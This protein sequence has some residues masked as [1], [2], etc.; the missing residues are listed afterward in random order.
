MTELST[1]TTLMRSLDVPAL[2]RIVGAGFVVRVLLWALSS[3]SGDVRSWSRVAR[4]V[5]A[6]GVRGLYEAGPPFRQSPVSALWAGLAANLSTWLEA[7]FELV[8]KVLPLS[9]DVGLVVLILT[10]VR[11][12]GGTELDA[13]RA[14]AIQ[15]TAM[16]AIWVT[17]HHGGLDSVLIFCVVAAVFL[18]DKGDRPLLAGIALA[19]A[20]HMHVVAVVLLPALWIAQASSARGAVV[21]GL[22]LLLALS[23]LALPLSIQGPEFLVNAV[24]VGVGSNR[25]GL[26]FV[27]SEGAELAVIGSWFDVVGAVVAAWSWKLCLVASLALGLL[28]RT[29]R[30]STL[31]LGSLVVA[32]FLVLTPKLGI[33]YAALPVALLAIVDQRRALLYS[34]L[35]GAYATAVYLGASKAEMP[36]VSN[37]AASISFEAGLLG[38]ASWLVLVSLVWT[39]LWPRSAAPADERSTTGPH[40]F[41]LPAVFAVVATPFGLALALATPPFQVADEPLHAFTACAIANGQLVP[42]HDAP[43]PYTTTFDVPASMVA[44]NR[45]IA[46]LKLPHHPESQASLDALL[47][48]ARIPHDPTLMHISTREETREL[49][50]YPPVMYGPQAVACGLGQAAGLRPM[51]LLT[52]MRLANLAA[53]LVLGV[54]ALWLLPVGREVVALMLLSPMALSSAASASA[55]GQLIVLM[56]LWLALVLKTATAP[57]DARPLHPLAIVGF[58]VLAFMLSMAKSVY[59]PLALAFVVIPPRCFSSRRA[60]VAAL[61]LVGAAA[62]VGAVVWIPQSDGGLDAYASSRGFD[63]KATLDARLDSPFMFLLAA[64]RTFFRERILTGV[65][66]TLGWRDTVLPFSS[67][68]LFWAALLPLMAL[69]GGPRS[70]T[71]RG[72]CLGLFG[73]GAAAGL[74]LFYALYFTPP[75]NGHVS[76]V[77][78]RHFIP[79]MLF[80][81][82]G[83][84][85]YLGVRVGARGRWALHVVVMLTALIVLQS[86]LGAVEARFY[87]NHR[88]VARVMQATFAVPAAKPSSR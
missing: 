50:V 19:G 67:I 47:A 26:Q 72:L 1:P 7:P 38:F 51:S 84:S 25:W 30:W 40:V 37:H 66:G 70:S 52:S 68:A 43:P 8:F 81:T 17:S 28:A 16:A 18:V 55:D 33:Q 5:A 61:A 88:D 6:H 46:R 27:F 83:T 57:D 79:P 34:A 71:W 77:Q 59:L 60:R 45:S 24:V 13:W 56:A 78:G 87:G 41:T 36:L 48:A 29:R 22:G 49:S 65:V 54:L 62:V 39:S 44:F 42:G 58:A 75:E 64:L 69:G 9:A 80:L 53:F 35:S 11:R 73:V 31:H 76:D 21:F 3:G 74:L 23:P 63:P 4:E 2:R 86:A 20:M 85:E 12:R 82:V 14:A 10:I 15:G 32:A